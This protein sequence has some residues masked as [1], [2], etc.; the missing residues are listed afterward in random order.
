MLVWLRLFFVWLRLLVRSI[1]QTVA[2]VLLVSVVAT[3]PILQFVSLGYM[4]ESAA[5]VSRR[6]PWSTCFP[7]SETAG[8]LMLI[9]LC[10]FVTWLPIWFLADLAYSAEIIE[11]GSGSARVLRLSARVSAFVWIAWVLWAVFRGGKIR[12]FLWPA[13][14]LAIKSL[15]SRQFWLDAE[16][17]LWQFAGSLRLP[18]LFLLGWM[19]SVGALIWLTFPASLIVLGL[20]SSSD[21]GAGLLGLVGAI[22]MTWVLLQLPLLQVKMARDY[23]FLSVLDVRESRRI[24]QAAP[25]SVCLATTI[26]FS[27]AIPLYLLRIEKPPSELWWIFSIF[28]VV[29]MF[30]AK[31]AIGWAVGRA[32]DKLVRND[33]SNFRLFW[34]WRYCAWLLQLAVALIYLGTLYLARFALWEGAASVF[35]Q[36][37]FLPPVPFFI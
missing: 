9:A 14:I 1:W 24:F 23:K 4:L 34:L 37:A 20:S 16:N 28:F 36:H 25:W 18:R 12:H 32:C 3:I 15:F 19:A 26:F 29:F 27:L 5:R 30:P 17:R 7:G 10:S 13:P 33:G 2:I 31:L 21:G 11:P 22:L 6:Q 8:K 35:L